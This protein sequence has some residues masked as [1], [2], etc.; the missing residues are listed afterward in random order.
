MSVSGCVHP[1][2]GGHGEEYHLVD[3]AHAQAGHPDA[4]KQAH[5]HDEKNL[6]KNNNFNSIFDIL[7]SILPKGHK[8]PL[9]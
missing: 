4:V 5:Q 9:L 3:L 2:V 7:K 1:L 8:W 6:Q